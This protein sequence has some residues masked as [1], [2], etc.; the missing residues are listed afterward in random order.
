MLGFIGGTGPEGRGLALRFAAAGHH[1]LV[2]SRDAQRAKI[3][4]EKLLITTPGL[5]LRGVINQ[6]AAQE[7]DPVL[8]TVPYK[9]QRSTLEALRLH[10]K[11]KLVVDVVA[12]VIFENGVAR[13][14]PVPEGS[15]AVEAQ[16]LLPDSKVVAAFQNISATDLLTLDTPIDGDVVVCSDHVEA[17]AMVM[18]LAQQINGVRAVDGGPLENARYVEELTALLLNINRIYKARSMVRITGI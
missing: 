1:V 6:E 16:N 11:G 2:G 3:T 8:V 18:A 12:P 17:K 7:S 10:L 9:A 15:A 13:A 4:V 5:E 14:V